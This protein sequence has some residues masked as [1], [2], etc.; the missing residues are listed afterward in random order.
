MPMETSNVQAVKEKDIRIQVSMLSLN[1]I[2]TF[3]PASNLN[4]L[5]DTGKNLGEGER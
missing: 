2:K 4:V 3:L 1:G 5:T